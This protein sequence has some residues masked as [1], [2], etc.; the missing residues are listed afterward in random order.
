MTSRSTVGELGELE[1][2]QALFASTARLECAPQAR[3]LLHYR[4]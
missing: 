1:L 2:Q 3:H 4:C